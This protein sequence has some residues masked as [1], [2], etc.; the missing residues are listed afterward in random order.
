L[1]TE[2]GVPP[3]G[4]HLDSIQAQ[5][6]VRLEESDVAEKIREAIENVERWIGAPG[7][8][9]GGRRKGRTRVRNQGSSTGGTRLAEAGN[10]YERGREPGEDRISEEDGWGRRATR[11]SPQVSATTTHQTNLAWA[12]QWLPDD[13]PCRPSSLRKRAMRNAQHSWH[14]MWQASAKSPA[15][16]TSIE[17][18]PSTDVLLLHQLI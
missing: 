2:V 16:S 7:G 17:A 15:P 14:S 6:R 3:L 1:E 9:R 10:G 8:D 5:F 13:D 18:P 12:L 11:G 4:I